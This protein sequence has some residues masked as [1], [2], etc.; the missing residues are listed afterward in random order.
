MVEFGIGVAWVSL[1]ITSVHLWVAQEFKVQ[2]E[3]PTHDN[4]GQM[5]HREV[6]HGSCQGI[7]I[8]DPMDDEKANGNSELHDRCL[9]W[10]VWS[11]GW[12]YAHISQEPHIMEE[13]PKLRHD[14]G[15]TEAVLLWCLTNTNRQYASV[16][17]TFPW[18]LPDVRKVFGITVTEICYSR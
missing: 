9:H 6:G 8:V 16:F 4:T 18:F 12:H 10:H 14:I 5:D 11:G 3:L 1:L 2:W 17:W 7:L 13:S 15:V